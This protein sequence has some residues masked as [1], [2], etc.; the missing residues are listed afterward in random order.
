MRKILPLILFATM[1]LCLQ[2]QDLHFTQFNMA[3]PHINPALT[4]GFYGT[5]RAGGI[6][7]SQWYS[8]FG[9]TLYSTPMAYVDAPV[10]RG[11]RKQ[12]WFGV[13]MTYSS[14]N[15]GTLKLGRTSLL[16]SLSYHFSL[17]KKQR[18]VLTLGYQWGNHSFR[19]NKIQDA[20]FEDQII[21]GGP[22]ADMFNTEPESFQGSNVGLSLSSQIAEGSKLL[23]GAGYFRL[24]RSN[25]SLLQ[26]GGGPGPGPGPNPGTGRTRL[27]SRLL[28]HGSL[29]QDIN[30]SFLVIPSFMYQKQ[31]SASELVIQAMGG[32][33]VPLKDQA[34]DKP[35][36]VLAMAGLGARF[37]D[38]LQVLIGGQYGPY[39]VGL[40]YDINISDLSEATQNVGGVEIAISYIAIIKKKPKP[41]PTI[42]CPRL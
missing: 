18:H 13:G 24:S 40:A 20:N 25:V 31:S 2:G 41:K 17:D 21:G 22:T 10:Y 29:E 15:A 3:G 23:I 28:V 6:Y 38:A 4:G 16:G 9:T 27:P 26:G 7:R 35:Q 34:A 14:D 19:V 42:F 36:E 11:F 5:F 37:G 30:E 1:G 33:R 32:A 8:G 12:D 39:R